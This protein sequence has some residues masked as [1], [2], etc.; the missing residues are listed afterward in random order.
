[1]LQIR[2][3]RCLSQLSLS[4]KMLQMRF[5]RYLSQLSPSYKMLQIIL[6]DLQIF[7]GSYAKLIDVF[8]NFPYYI[9]GHTPIHF[10]VQPPSLYSS[11]SIPCID[12]RLHVSYS[13]SHSWF[14]M[15]S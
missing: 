10:R 3:V 7:S 5:V 13:F 2:F 12:L 14:E 8:I 4:Y 15:C 9:V 6:E 1:M 11:T